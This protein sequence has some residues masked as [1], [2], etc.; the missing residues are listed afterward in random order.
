MVA[1]HQQLKAELQQH[2]Q[3][4]IAEL[5]DIDARAKH[6]V[7]GYETHQADDATH[8]F[9]QAAELAMRNNVAH[10]LREVEDALSRFEADTYGICVNCGERI[11]I[12]RLEAIPHTSL[13]LRC[14]ESRDFRGGL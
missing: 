7:V 10:M 12:A 14:A 2:R 5:Q 4:L 9:D 11:D 8:A 13:C 3:V 6:K 1:T